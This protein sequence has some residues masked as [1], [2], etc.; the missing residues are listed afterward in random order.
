MRGGVVVMMSTWY[1]KQK[2]REKRVCMVVFWTS[3]DKVY[4]RLSYKVGGNGGD[5]GGTQVGFWRDRYTNGDWFVRQKVIF[6]GQDYM[7]VWYW[8]MDM[9]SVLRAKIMPWIFDHRSNS[10]NFYFGVY[11]LDFDL[12]K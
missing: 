10:P 7:E 8:L 3:D 9:W 11:G 4:T 1:L 6:Q 5:N 2:G 12:I